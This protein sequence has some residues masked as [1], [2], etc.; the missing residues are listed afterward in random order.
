MRPGEIPPFKP[1]GSQHVFALNCR[2][3]FD[4]IVVGS[5]PAATALAIQLTRSGATVA[6]LAS[7]KGQVRRPSEVVTPQTVRALESLGASDALEGAKTCRGLLTNWDG[8]D[9]FY[10][11]DLL[12]CGSAF[13]LDP[14][15]F[16]QRLCGIAT[17]AGA[18]IVITR[19][20]EAT[21][22]EDGQ[23]E[24]AVETSGERR[25]MRCRSLFLAHGR[26]ARSGQELY[27][28]HFV[29]KQ[30][31]IEVAVRRTGFQDDSL[32][33][34]PSLN[35]WWYAS[36]RSGDDDSIFFLTDSDL[37]PRGRR[38]RDAFIASE[39]RSTR[40]LSR[41]LQDCQE[42]VVVGGC[43]ARFSVASAS[44][45]ERCF[46]VGDAALALDPL[47]GGGIS[48]AIESARRAA[49]AMGLG[50][51]RDRGSYVSWVKGRTGVEA[52]KRLTTYSQARLPG[53]RTEYWERR[54]LCLSARAA[55][56][57]AG[58]ETRRKQ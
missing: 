22:L 51:P 57:V 48:F 1:M 27:A 30:V 21:H 40:L 10:D 17:Q 5:G 3:E 13:A 14:V 34:E 37:L 44:P 20:W 23:W 7:R 31:A 12:Q 33:V 4:A 36:P 53:P 32:V 9:R 16:R 46:A 15:Q 11:Y 43:D 58:A 8:G 45:S 28:R 35:G 54:R 47:S 6:I 24:L 38:A 41:C 49:S 50:G 55:E 42:C 26:C 18:R 52:T 19:T 56:G 39:L 25:R 29:D 2:A